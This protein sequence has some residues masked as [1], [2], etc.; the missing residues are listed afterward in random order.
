MPFG[1]QFS[2]L[3]CASR[4][5][6]AI[7][8]YVLISFIFVLTGNLLLPQAASAQVNASDQ[9]IQPIRFK[10]SPTRDKS[11]AESG[12]NP[13]KVQGGPF[14]VQTGGSNPLNGEDVGSES[15]PF[16][17][18]IDNDGDLDLFAG[19]T[20]GTIYYYENTGSAS[21]ATYVQRTGGSNPANGIDVGSWCTPALVDIDDDDD[22]DLFISDESSNIFYYR[23]T[24][25]VSSPTFSSTTSPLTG[26]VA[27]DENKPGFVDIDNDGDYDVFLGA[28][29]G[30]LVY[31]ENTGSASSATFVQRTG[32]SNPFNG[33][34][35]GSYSSVNFVDIDHDGDW[36]AFA[37]EEAGVINFF[38]NTGSTA[39]PTFV[40]RTGN[41]NYLDG[42]DVGNYSRPILM[43]LDNDGDWDLF[44]GEEDGNFNYYLNNEDP[45]TTA[46]GGLFNNI[47]LWL[48]ADAG[49]TG[50][51]NVTAWA[52]QTNQSN[53]A[54][55]ATSSRQ[56]SK[57][58]GAIN[59]QPALTFDGTD[60]FLDVPYSDGLHHG[61]V[62]IFS[63]HKSTDA[64]SF[65]SPFTSRDGS[66]T[67]GYLLYED[68]S[69]L[70]AFW[71]AAS[72]SWNAITGG[73]VTFNSFELVSV[74]GQTGAGDAEKYL[75]VDGAQ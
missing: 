45:V 22:F 32:G 19:A 23:N 61:K 46:P 35:V 65:A 24:G 31:F 58:D 42:V 15:A 56:P 43:D 69:D 12:L 1:T 41:A 34:D 11:V 16:L 55:Q 25:T 37:G 62:Q 64:P 47:V 39:S 72:S 21:S 71:T 70:Y 29:N 75:Y 13:G 26:P 5:Q 20:D 57:T 14:S 49:V 60:D 67:E 50:T 73:S 68:D 33:V 9:D 63:V 7:N 38:E 6:V 40:Q 74:S 51:S 27:T 18:D 30:G 2:S 36:D 3:Q 52:D 66:T 8:W 10:P 44:I 17:V 54:A 28:S 4:Q 53:D 59:Y 48:K